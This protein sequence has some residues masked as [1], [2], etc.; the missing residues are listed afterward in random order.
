MSVP[1]ECTLDAE[2]SHEHEADKAELSA[3]GNQESR[4]GL[5]EE[6][7]VDSVDVDERKH[8]FLHRAHCFEPKP[9]LE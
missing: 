7:I 2:S 1:G 9:G 8:F 5:C 6:S 3:A 4:H